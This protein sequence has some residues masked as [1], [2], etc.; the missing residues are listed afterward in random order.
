MK[1][2]G[3]TFDNRLPQLNAIINT[4]G[5]DLD[6]AYVFHFNRDK[7]ILFDTA[8]TYFSLFLVMKLTTYLCKK[9]NISLN[10]TNK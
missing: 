5:G 1:S 7:A 9:E 2:I 10:Y 8:I 3:C 4:G 6:L